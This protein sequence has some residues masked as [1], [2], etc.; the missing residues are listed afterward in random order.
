MPI[1][2]C[3]LLGIAGFVAGQ[4]ALPQTGLRAQYFSNLTRSGQPV[5]TTIDPDASTEVLASGTAAAWATY[6]VEWTG[7][8][9]INS[10]GAYTFATVTDDGSEMDV[11]DVTVVRNGG[12]HGP[13][14]A[15]GRIELSAGVHPIRVRYEQA[16]GG[17]QLELKYGLET[18]ALS[19]IPSG[20]LLPDVTSL[21]A[22]RVR[23]FFPVLSGIAVMLLFIAS[24]RFLPED[25]S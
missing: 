20:V 24:R 13:Q 3:I 11:A 6:S 9:V 12:L 23:R 1:A 22:Y 8:I 18:E 7:A 21:T 16:G 5:A 2:A 17:F 19:A 4:F 15:T 14:E 25:S 10:A